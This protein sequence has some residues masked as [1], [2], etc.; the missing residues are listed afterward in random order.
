[1]TPLYLQNSTETTMKTP[2]KQCKKTPRRRCRRR[3]RA[4]SVDRVHHRRMPPV[5]VACTMP[6]AAAAFMSP[7][8]P[9]T[10]MSFWL[11]G[12]L[13]APHLLELAPQFFCNSQNAPSH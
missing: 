6:L 13:S 12:V 8:C 3:R 9:Q 5:I 10:L 4:T 11:V 1:M 7:Q 2:Q